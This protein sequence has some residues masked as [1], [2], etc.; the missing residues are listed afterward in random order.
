MCVCVCIDQLTYINILVQTDKDYG[1]LVVPDYKDTELLALPGKLYRF[2]DSL[3][4]WVERCDGLV[5]VLYNEGMDTH[6]IV[7]RAFISNKMYANHS[8]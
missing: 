5:K 2:D 4:T 1:N 8:S 6:R 3:G 7:M